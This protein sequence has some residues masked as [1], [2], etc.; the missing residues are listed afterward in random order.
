MTLENI[1]VNSLFLPLFILYDLLQNVSFRWSFI[2]S[3]IY[4]IFGVF[5]VLQFMSFIIIVILVLDLLL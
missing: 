2:V 3:M 5:L 4:F 1:L